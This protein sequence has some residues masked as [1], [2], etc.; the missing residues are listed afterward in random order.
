M[1]KIIAI[2]NQKGGVA[3]TTTTINLGVG[4]SKVGKR[5]MLIDADPQGHLTM[6]LGF[7]KNLRVTLKTMMENIIMGLEFDP[8][9]AI[10]HHEEGIDVIPSDTRGSQ[11]SYGMNYQK[12]G[13]ELMSQDE[14]AVMDGGKCI[15]QV[16]GVRPFFSNKYDICKHKNYK[17]LSDYDKKN[18]FDIEK[19]LSTNLILKPEDEVELYQM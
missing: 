3:K 4:L 11:R 7:P 13:K 6:G 8:R 2:A 16:R 12:I 1:C 17:Y 5:V 15:L 19:H 10:L 18:T 9:E 14:I